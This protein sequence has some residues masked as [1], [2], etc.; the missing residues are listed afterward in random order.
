MSKILDLT[1]RVEVTVSDEYFKEWNIEE[2]RNKAGEN[3]LSWGKKNHSHG[4]G[5]EWGNPTLFDR[6]AP[7]IFRNNTRTLKRVDVKIKDGNE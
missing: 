2:Q 6:V 4:W 7:Q 3:M 5:S 1:I